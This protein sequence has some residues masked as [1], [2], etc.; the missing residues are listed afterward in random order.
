MI[1]KFNDS[2]DFINVEAD[3]FHEEGNFIKA[4]KRS[5][6]VAMAD[7]S[8]VKTAHISDRRSDEDDA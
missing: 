2:L 6:L 5:E 1:I 7:I 4:Y 3:E 8:C